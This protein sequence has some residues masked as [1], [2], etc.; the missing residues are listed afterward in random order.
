MIVFMKNKTII[1]AVVAVLVLVVI[2]ILAMGKKSGSPEGQT[3]ESTLK[4]LI[5][6]EGSQKCAVTSKNDTSE[7]T[8][9]IFVANGLMKGEF[10]SIA[11]GQTV[12]SYMIIKENKSYIWSDMMPQGFVMELSAETPTSEDPNQSMDVNQKYSYECDDWTADTAVFELPA[13]IKFMSTADLINEL[14]Q[15]VAN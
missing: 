6:M 11:G 15:E 4:E 10:T 8:G 12:K 7:S 9:E 14:P 13:G 3:G 1:Y 2:V 5:A